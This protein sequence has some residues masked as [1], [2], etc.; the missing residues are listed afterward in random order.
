MNRI[1]QWFSLLLVLLFSGCSTHQPFPNPQYAP[2]QGGQIEYYRFGQGS[3]IVL[4]PGYVTDVSSWSHRFLVALAKQHQVIVLNNRNVG[5]SLIHSTRY[6]SEDLANDTYQLIQVLGLKK[7]AVLGIS[8]GGMIAQQFAVSHPNALGQLI[9]INT[10][11][12][13][14]RAVHPDFSVENRLLN[15]PESKTGRYVVAV[16][17][18]FPSSWRLRMGYALIADRF[19]PPHYTEINPATVMPQ[20]QHLIMAWIKNDSVAKQLA[21]LHL[22]VLIL[23]GGADQVIPPVNSRILANTISQA[24]LLRWPDGGHAMIYQYPEEIAGVVNTFI[25]GHSV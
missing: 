13:G 3:P 24:Q 4:I 23:N 10:A 9:L 16:Q 11:I 22:P 25:A 5:G 8:M 15:M 21:Y 20:Q 18:F 7:P 12:A 17:L 14:K 6:E 19:H 2:V 1:I